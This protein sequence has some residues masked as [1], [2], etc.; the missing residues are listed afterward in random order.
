MS[1]SIRPQYLRVCCLSSASSPYSFVFQFVACGTAKTHKHEFKAV[2]VAAACWKHHN[3]GRLG[4]DECIFRWSTAGSHNISAESVP[5]GDKASRRATD[6]SYLAGADDWAIL[7]SCGCMRIY[8]LGFSYLG[9]SCVVWWLGYIVELSDHLLSSLGHVLVCCI[10]IR[11]C[12][13]SHSETSVF[14][15]PTGWPFLAST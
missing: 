10:M 3:L 15:V 9:L 8:V 6:E 7:A 12:Y 4:F 11:E 1:F 14:E 5:T 2:F 13:R